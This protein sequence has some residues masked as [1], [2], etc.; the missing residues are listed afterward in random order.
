MAP[1]TSIIASTLRIALTVPFRS[2]VEN[3]IQYVKE[4]HKQVRLKA[5]GSKV[6]TDAESKSV[7]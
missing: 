6:K 3:M 7:N 5:A 2:D 1:A 4:M